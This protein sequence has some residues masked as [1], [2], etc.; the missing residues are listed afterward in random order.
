M[1][2]HL[3]KTVE[4]SNSKIW[5]SGLC[6]TGPDYGHAI[7]TFLLLAF[8]FAVQCAVPIPWLLAHYKNLGIALLAVL[9][10]SFLLS[11]LSGLY[12]AFSDPGI[13]QK[14]EQTP[15]SVSKFQRVVKRTVCFRGRAISMEYCGI[16]K[17]WRPPRSCHCETCNNCVRRFDHHCPWL[18]NCIGIR[19]YAAFFAFVL[20]TVVYLSTL[21]VCFALSVHFKA[22][23][24]HRTHPGVSYGS[25]LG[26]SIGSAGM[27]VNAVVV[28]VSAPVLITVGLL[29]IFH[30]VLMMHNM[31]ATETYADGPLNRATE[32]DDLLG[33]AAF[34]MLLFSKREKSE[35]TNVSYETA[36]KEE[37]ELSVLVESQ[38]SLE[39]TTLRTV[40]AP[41]RCVVLNV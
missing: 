27:I 14:S 9:I 2:Q 36:Y 40:S 8:S 39:T 18:G 16:C 31:T 3:M 30:I 12:T 19:N 1:A 21:V 34:C 32:N 35:V 6:L 10:P 33:C 20:G 29:L 26:H 13:V 25:S 41:Q 37:K 4:G 23:Q 5:G 28:A 11:L 38:S 7:L 17:I 15:E 22:D 24:F